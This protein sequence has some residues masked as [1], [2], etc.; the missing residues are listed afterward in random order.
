[1]VV[2]QILLIHIGFFV[3]KPKGLTLV[4]TTKWDRCSLLLDLPNLR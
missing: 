4:A 1:V 3:S 2:V